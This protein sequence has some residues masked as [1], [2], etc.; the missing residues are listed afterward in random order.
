MQHEKTEN[1]NKSYRLV[2]ANSQESWHQHLGS[3]VKQNKKIKKKTQKARKV[4]PKNTS[5]TQ[6]T[7]S[8]KTIVKLYGKK[9]ENNINTN[10]LNNF[11]EK[12]K[13]KRQLLILVS[14]V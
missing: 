6:I 11:G 10:I 8:T 3:T 14:V 7:S 2:R 5:K 1:K 9:K 13:L 4:K 12:N